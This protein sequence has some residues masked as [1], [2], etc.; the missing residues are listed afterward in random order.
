[1]TP[2]VDVASY[3]VGSLDVEDL[4]I[5]ERHLDQCLECPQE[6]VWLDWTVHQL[7]KTRGEKR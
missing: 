2:H 5:F 3:A 1:M 7:A 4:R 6:L